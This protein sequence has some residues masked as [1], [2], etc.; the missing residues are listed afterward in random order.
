MA[1][2]RCEFFSDVLGLST[3]MT[4]ILP[5]PTSGQI[6]MAGAATDDLPPVL[7]LL[8]GLSDDDTIWLRRTSVERYVAELGLAVVMPAVGR[9]FYTDEVAG[10]AYWTFVS[11]E[12]P[13]LVHR[14]FRVSDRREDTF[15]AGLSMGGY[16][17]LK[18]ALRQPDR[19]AAAASLSGALDLA[20]LAGPGGGPVWPSDPRMFD[21]ILGADHRVAPEDDLFRLLADADPAQLP[22]LWL[23][24]G[25]ADEL[26]PAHQSFRQACHEAGLSPAGHDTDGADHEWGLWD[27][28]LQRVLDWLPLRRAAPGT[29]TITQTPS[30]ATSASRG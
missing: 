17:A 26:Y 14:F 15:V 4:V 29:R 20:G 6:G 21:R 19:F 25:T 5:Q 16:G 9:S 12:L 30:A 3:S 23:G 13:E 24:C 11:Q 10:G 8:H 22:A 1:H 7:Y 28:D 2:L 18:L 27:A